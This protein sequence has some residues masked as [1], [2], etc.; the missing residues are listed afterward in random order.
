MA[1]YYIKLPPSSGGSSGV[2]S[3]NSLTG[4]L[5]LVAGSNIT[6]T[7]SGSTITIASTGGGG[8]IS[9]VS[10]ATANGFAGTSSGGSTPALTLS[11]TVTGVL[12]GNGT[13]INA[14]VPGTD[15]QAPGNYITALTGD[16]TASGPGSATLTL[17]TVNSNIGTFNTLT[18]NAKGLVTAA[19]NTT[20]Q[21]PITLTTTGTTGAATFVG[22]TL[23]IPQYGAGSGLTRAVNV[24]STNTNAGS[25]MAVDYV[26]IVT[27]TATITLPTAV[28][29]TNLYT[30]K[31]QGAFTTTINTTSSQT[32]DGSLTVSLPI[33]YTS[34]SLISDGANWNIV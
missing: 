21:A 8:G 7:P 15:Y 29:N 17:A 3:L 16:A 25:S 13:S 24:V 10:V 23:N 19:S 33:Q 27:A 9:A 4:A 32:I 26:Y 6:L 20:Y 34:L 2:S 22:N 28:G 5:T 31:N 14:G 11:T 1:S 18:V 12:V 30:I